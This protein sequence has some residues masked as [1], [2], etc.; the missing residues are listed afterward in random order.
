MDGTTR[1]RPFGSVLFAQSAFYHPGSSAANA[2]AG[3]GDKTPG[4]ALAVD[5]FERSAPVRAA[6]ASADSAK[7]RSSGAGLDGIRRSLI[8]RVRTEIAQGTYVAKDRL[9]AAVDALLDDL[10]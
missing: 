5:S 1:I 2:R 6:A 4:I 3:D 7:L 10:K 8:E 9:D